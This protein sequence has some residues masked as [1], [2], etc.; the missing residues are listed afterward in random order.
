[1]TALASRWQRIGLCMWQ[2]CIDMDWGHAQWRIVPLCLESTGLQPVLLVY[3]HAGSTSETP[4]APQTHP[5]AI[6][7]EPA[8][9]AVCLLPTHQNV[10]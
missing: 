5:P 6:W 8:L 4:S 3:K 1:M 2:Q 7:P 9:W 10:G